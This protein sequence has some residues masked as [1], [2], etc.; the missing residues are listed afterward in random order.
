MAHSYGNV[1]V[2][3]TQQKFRDSKTKYYTSSQNVPWCVRDADSHRDLRIPTVDEA[4]KNFVKIRE[5]IL[6]DHFNNEALQLLN[7]HQ[8][9]KRLKKIKRFELV[10]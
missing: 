10:W 9:V 2:E 3:T 8:L 7:H 5:K 1:V 6:D 4:V